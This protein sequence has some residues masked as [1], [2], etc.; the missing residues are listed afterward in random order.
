LAEFHALTSRHLLAPT[1]TSWRAVLT[2]HCW[3]GVPLQS[4]ICTLVPL[5][6]PPPT[7]SMHLPRACA[8]PSEAR[9]QYC[10]GVLLQS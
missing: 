7:T 6:V 9:T 10:A 1:F 3:A 4:Q 2:R 5:A 8:V